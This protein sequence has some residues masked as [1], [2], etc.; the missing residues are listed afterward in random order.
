[1]DYACVS[2]RGGAAERGC[3][4]L[5]REAC[6]LPVPDISSIVGC[7]RS[8]PSRS[9]PETTERRSR[10]HP[11]C[12][13]SPS[14]HADAP[15]NGHALGLRFPAAYGVA[16]PPRHT[17]C[18]VG[19][20]RA[21]RSAH[22]T[23]RRARRGPA[24]SRRPFRIARWPR[25]YTP[26]SVTSQR[27]NLR[28]CYATIAFVAPRH[29]KCCGVQPSSTTRLLGSSLPVFLVAVQSSQT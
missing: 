7:P 29:A 1:M 23:G 28:R 27:P 16:Q 20:N 4:E 14:P 21:L 26:S 18:H 22:G 24:R 8:R 5:R 10:S 17:S 2:T 11:P 3:L 15:D 6:V 19:P 12:R 25:P 13:G 9:A